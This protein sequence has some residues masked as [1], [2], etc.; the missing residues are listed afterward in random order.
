MISVPW[1]ILAINCRASPTRWQPRD[2]RQEE[3]PCP[4]IHIPPL[5]LEIE[6]RDVSHWWVPPYI[7][8]ECPS[9]SVSN[10]KSPL[11]SRSTTTA[12]FDKS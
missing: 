8:F 9:R 3:W 4:V 6:R 1:R 5:S 7:F 12:A 11:S 10:N 2:K